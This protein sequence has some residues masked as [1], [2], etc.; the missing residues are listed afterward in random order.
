MMTMPVLFCTR[1]RFLF[2]VCAVV[3]CALLGH[4]GQT[5]ALATTP[6]YEFREDHDPSGIGKYFLGREIARVMG[7]EGSDWLERST[8]PQEEGSD[9]LVP[10][11]K[12]KAGDVVADIGCGTGFYTR[13]FARAVGTNG[14]VYAEDIQPEMLDILTNKLGTEGINNVRPVLGTIT[15]P[16]LPR[17][18]LDLILMVDVYHEFDHP[19][20]MV[21]AM[22]PSLRAQGRIAIVEFRGEDERLAIKKL[23]KMT[24]AQVRKEMSVHSLNWVATITNLPQQHII[25]FNTGS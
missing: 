4:A 11:L 19:Y 3:G 8:R 24:E 21:S 23:H 16:K 22:I 9:L 17:A 14:V 1:H 2:C 20:E 25:L 6:R 10:A 13:R 12:L 15:D 18:S 7:H 5:N